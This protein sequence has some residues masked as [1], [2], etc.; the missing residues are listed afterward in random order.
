MVNRALALVNFNENI[1]F[2]NIYI[3]ATNF[4]KNIIRMSYI[5]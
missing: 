3:F 5:S 4:I 2:K 1:E